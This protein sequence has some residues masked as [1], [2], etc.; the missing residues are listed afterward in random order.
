MA[1][2]LK[3]TQDVSLCSPLTLDQISEEIISKIESLGIT[4]DGPIIEGQIPGQKITIQNDGEKTFSPFDHGV[5]KDFD[6]HVANVDFSKFDIILGPVHRETLPFYQKY[7]ENKRDDQKLYL[8]FTT[9]RE[10]SYSPNKLIELIQSTDLM[11]FSPD[12]EHE[13]I[14]ESLKVIPLNPNQIQLITLGEKGGILRTQ[15][16]ESNFKAPVLDKIEDTTG[17][18]DA[19][20]SSF[21]SNFLE[22]NDP[23]ES[24]NNGKEKA[25]ECLMRVGSTPIT[26][27]NSER[28]AEN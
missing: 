4:F 8:D 10:F 7:L 6:Q 9:L 14:V 11:Q 28:T 20:F 21:I 15:Q 13:T 1:W 5:L 3:N 25:M 24:I 27:F 22:T 26:L 12:K 19:F 17:A 23:E 16:V 2:H 18:G